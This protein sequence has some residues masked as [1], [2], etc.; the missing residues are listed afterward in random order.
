MISAF[1]ILIGLAW[2]V[3]ARV[4]VNDGVAYC[5]YPCTLYAK[6]SLV[7]QVQ[8]YGAALLACMLLPRTKMRSLS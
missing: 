4:V 5:L 8:Q 6:A 3:H 7:L 2:Y 1:V